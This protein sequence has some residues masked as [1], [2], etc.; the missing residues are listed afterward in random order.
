M[1]VG[2]IRWVS[3][4]PLYRVRGQGVYKEEDYLDRRVVSLREVLANLA[5]KLHRLVEHVR[6]WLSSWSCG[7]IAAWCDM[8]LLCPPWWYY[9]HGGGSPAVLCDVVLAVVFVITSWFP[10]VSYRSW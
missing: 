8:V 6:A 7:H 3:W 10:R 2:F 4:L 1:R 9:R 5:C